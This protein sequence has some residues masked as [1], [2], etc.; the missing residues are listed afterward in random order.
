MTANELWSFRFRTK[1]G[2]AC[3]CF[4]LGLGLGSPSVRFFSDIAMEALIGC[5]LSAE[6]GHAKRRRV[7]TGTG[8]GAENME[9]CPSPEFIIASE[10]FFSSLLFVLFSFVSFNNLYSRDSW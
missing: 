7:G 10:V 8:A 2:K 9:F 3:I 6:F 4:E 1:S 5:L